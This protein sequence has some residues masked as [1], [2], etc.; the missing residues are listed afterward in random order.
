[1][2]AIV[3]G[4]LAILSLL[5][6]QARLVEFAPVTWVLESK[7]LELQR[8]VKHEKKLPAL[9]YLNES[10]A[11]KMTARSPASF[12]G[13]RSPPHPPVS[14]SICVSDPIINRNHHNTNWKCETSRLL[15]T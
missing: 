4:V 2:S 8:L 9:T 15:E 11:A 7:L 3:V 14:E 1:M 13:L 10:S 5:D 12:S 6:G